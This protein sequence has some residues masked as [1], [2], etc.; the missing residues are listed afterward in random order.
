MK[1][2]SDLQNLTLITGGARSGKSE[3][4]ESLAKNSSCVYYL[5]TMQE[6]TSDL[7]NIERIKQHKERRPKHWT[8]LEVPLLL[9]RSLENLPTG[10]ASC[11]IDCLTLYVSNLLLANDLYK[12]PLELIEEQIFAQVQKLIVSVKRR[13]DI[14]FLVVT[15]EVGWGIVPEN[16]LGRTYRDIAGATNQSFAVAASKVWLS[17]MGLQIKLKPKFDSN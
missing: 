15:N 17:C 8:T 6:I 14:N 3:F 16:A 11:I 2:F 12:K 5:A 13:S 1:S 10:S 7:D 4:A 9:H